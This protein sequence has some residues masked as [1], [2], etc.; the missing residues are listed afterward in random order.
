MDNG[1][2]LMKLLILAFVAFIFLLILNYFGVID[3]QALLHDLLSGFF[4]LFKTLLGGA[5]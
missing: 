2:A 5:S 1:D 4:D 3:L